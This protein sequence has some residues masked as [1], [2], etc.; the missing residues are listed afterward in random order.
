VRVSARHGKASPRLF[1]EHLRKLRGKEPG[2]AVADRAGIPWRTYYDIESGRSAVRIDDVF[3]LA[4]ALKLTPFELLEPVL[5]LTPER[6]LTDAVWS[7][8]M[9]QAVVEHARSYGAE[10]D[11]TYVVQAIT[12]LTVIAKK[13]PR[14]LPTLSALLGSM[15]QNLD[16]PLAD[17]IRGLQYEADRRAAQHKRSTPTKGHQS[18]RRP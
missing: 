2:R 6:Q 5:Q 3:S 15:A 1:G 17:R 13:A 7:N 16:L 11:N 18:R 12:A 10:V 8:A 9:L 14:H 4:A